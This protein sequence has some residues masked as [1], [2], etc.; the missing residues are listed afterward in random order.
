MRDPQNEGFCRYSARIQTAIRTG[1]AN[2]RI[3]VTNRRAKFA[4]YIG[5]TLRFVDLAWEDQIPAL[6]ENRIDIIMSGMSITDMRR[7]SI[8]FSQPYYR[9]GLMAM[10]RKGDANRFPLSFFGLVGQ[11]PSMHFG[12]VRGTTGEAFVNRNFASAR[13]ITA[14]QTTREAM[15][16]LLTIAL[17][18]PDR[19]VHSGRTDSAHAA[20]GKSIDGSDGAALTADRRVSGLGHA[21]N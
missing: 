17:G 2:I 12:V 5:K 15:Y 18:E 14:Y 10:V 7:M 3:T 4:R 8:A 11:A 6:L 9:S 19:R 20:G 1:H 13:R 21:Q 16:A